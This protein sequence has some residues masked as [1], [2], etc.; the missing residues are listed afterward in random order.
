MLASLVIRKLFTA[1]QL[2]AATAV[3]LIVLEPSVYV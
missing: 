2:T 1:S 3:P